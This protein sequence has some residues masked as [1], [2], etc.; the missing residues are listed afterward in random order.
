MTNE[1]LKGDSTYNTMQKSFDAYVQSSTTIL[2]LAPFAHADAIQ[3]AMFTCKHGLEYAGLWARN[4]EDIGVVATDGPKETKPEILIQLTALQ[5]FARL[6]WVSDGGDQ[7]SLDTLRCFYAQHIQTVVET[8]LQCRARVPLDQFV[9]YYRLVEK[10]IKLISSNVVDELEMTNLCHEI[11]KINCE[12]EWVEL[13]NVS[14]GDHATCRHQFLIRLVRLAKQTA[15][16]SL[17]RLGGKQVDLTESLVKVLQNVEKERASMKIWISANEQQFADIE[18]NWWATCRYGPQL[19][20]IV[21]ELL[22]TMEKGLSQV[23][24][25]FAKATKQQFPSRAILENPQILVNMEMQKGFLDQ[26]REAKVA[27][28]PNL[29]KECCV[30][31]GGGGGHVGGR[32]GWGWGWVW[33]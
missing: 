14:I 21:Q 16:L 15:H 7:Q 20:A 22:S 29:D 19:V 8:E 12:K 3:P 2:A 5:H 27:E 33:G 30:W 11:T 10:Y 6:V 26:I 24:Q 9:A 31:G 4:F 18:H 28:V 32:W 17:L 25:D 13:L 23:V 1:Q